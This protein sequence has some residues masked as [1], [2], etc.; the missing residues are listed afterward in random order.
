M[1]AREFGDVALQMLRA[2]LVER[3]LVSAFQHRPE[4]L[5]AVGARHA[6]DVL[7]NR[8]LDALMRVRDAFVGRRVVGVDHSARLGILGD[9]AV[10]GILVR[11]LDHAGVDL[12][13]GPI[14][15]ADHRRHVHRAA[16]GGFGPLGVRLVLALAAKVGLVELYWAVER[17]FAV[18]VSPSLTYAVQHEPRRRLGDTDIAFQLHGR[19]RFKVGQAE[20]NRN[21]PLAHRD[22][23]PLHGGARLD[24]EIGPAIR[25]PIR[26]LGMAGFTGAERSA[27]GAVATVRPDHRFKPRGRRFLGREHVHQLNDGKSFAVGFTRCVFRHFR[28]PFRHLEYRDR[29]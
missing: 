5:D 7:G 18:T 27:F 17:A 20:V 1:F 14:L 3:S 24:A 19:D 4:R 22:F 23:R 28:S 26:H 25:A 9:E 21:R 12:V 29:D 16:S 8:V 10:Q 15:R 13:G 11:A 2:D 6:V